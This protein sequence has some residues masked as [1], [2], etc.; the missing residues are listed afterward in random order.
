[1]PGTVAHDP[2]RCIDDIHLFISVNSQTRARDSELEDED[3]AEDDHVK[4][5]QHLVVV[6]STHE[7]SHCNQEK[8]D[9]HRNDSSND[10]NTGHQTQALAPGSHANEQ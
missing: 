6:N 5:E 3:Q 2:P 1:M 7:P 10:M 4:E 9:S 8:E